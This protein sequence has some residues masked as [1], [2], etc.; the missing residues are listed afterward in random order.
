MS[1]KKNLI[2]RGPLLIIL[3]G[4]CF[5]TTGTTQ[6][7]AFDLFPGEVT[8]MIIGALRLLIGS[9]ALLGLCAIGKRL[10]N[11]RTWPLGIT[12][13]AAMGVLGYQL[14]F[15]WAVK[16]T[17]VAVGTVV[18][19]GAA[20]I[21]GGLMAWIFLKE[22]PIKVWYPATAL[23]LVGL[24]LLT[25]IG[26]ISVDSRGILL[27]FA[28]ATFYSVYIISG[29]VLIQGRDADAVMG[30]LF[31]IGAI[32][33]IPVFIIFPTAWVFTGKGMAIALHL[34]V[35]TAALAYAL[36]LA[37]LR[38]TNT[39]AAVTLTLVEPLAAASWGIFLLGEPTTF[40]SVLGITAILAS[41]VLLSVSGD[42]GNKN[43]KPASAKEET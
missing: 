38:T 18:G 32:F 33:C 29:K 23:A 36:Y 39:S 14:S 34:G 30:V 22:K 37:G 13:L 28:A 40:N 8:P 12:F 11:L 6:A 42:K 2:A 35:I 26:T 17:G 21:I 25:L 9:V 7:L 43:D 16:Y 31:G 15:F 3:S 1:A 4:L 20:P 10:P 27:A 19:I 5:S 24:G 41:T